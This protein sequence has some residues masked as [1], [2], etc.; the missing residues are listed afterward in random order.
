MANGMIYVEAH[1]FHQ[2]EKLVKLLS[3]QKFPGHTGEEIQKTRCCK[4]Y[5]VRVGAIKKN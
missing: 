2:L 5:M 4:E 3:S 1:I